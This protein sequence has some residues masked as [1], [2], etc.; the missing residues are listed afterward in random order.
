L[1]QDAA[2][3]VGGAA[4]T[5][6]HYKFDGFAGVALRVG[7]RA[8]PATHCHSGKAHAQRATKAGGRLDGVHG[9]S[10]VMSF[11]ALWQR[12]IFA[13]GWVCLDLYWNKLT[14]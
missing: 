11:H 13:V 2:H 6:G 8:E 10:P 7:G 4:C 3:V 14:L 9:L 5:E 1:G 12:K